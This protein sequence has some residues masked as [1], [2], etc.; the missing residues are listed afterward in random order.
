MTMPPRL[1]ASIRI[2]LE[3]QYRE[4]KAAHSQTGRALGRVAALLGKEDGS[5]AERRAVRA[6]AQTAPGDG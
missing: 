4:L 5:R 3:Q 1:D 6:G 2:T